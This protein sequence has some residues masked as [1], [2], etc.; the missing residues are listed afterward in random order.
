MER[1]HLRRP[2]SY[3]HFHR[4]PVGLVGGSLRPEG[5]AHPRPDRLCGN[6]LFDG[7]CPKRPAAFHPADHPRGR[8]RLYRR[9][10]GDCGHDHTPAVHGLR[11]GSSADL[12]HHRRRSRAVHRRFIGGSDGLP[13][14][15]F[16]HGVVC[17][18]GNSPGRLLGPGR[19][20][21]SGGIQ[22]P[23]ILFEFPFRFRF[24]DSHNDLRGRDDRPGGPAGDSAGPLPLRG[25]P[26]GRNP[27]FV[28]GGR[29]GLCDHGG[30][31][32]PGRPP[33]GPE[34]RPKRLQ[35]DFVPDP[36][37]VRDHLSSPGHRDSCLSTLHFAVCSRL[38]HRRNYAGPQHPRDPQLP[39]GSPRRRHGD[40]AQRSPHRTH[41]G[42]G[43]GRLLQRFLRD[44]PD[45]HSDRRP[46]HRS[47]LSSPASPSKSPSGGKIFGGPREIHLSPSAP[48]RLVDI[49]DQGFGTFPH[50]LA[51]AFRQPPGGFFLE[52]L[53]EAVPLLE[54]NPVRQVLG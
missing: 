51:Q 21:F 40:C 52:G 9:H 35:K 42:A 49:A 54:E 33:L 15:L 2:I 37:L 41:P 3:G 28:D 12:P 19:S 18:P 24:T 1:A 48:D 7:L 20:G 22:S 13:E 32:P 29:R 27:E 26:M 34:M 6:D 4:A 45:L 14:H 8:F 25:K 31:Q 10:P 43:S 5:H 46:P 39:G 53:L 47:S 16:C 36:P 17:G 50:G 23:R 30:S 38:V 11:H 44:S